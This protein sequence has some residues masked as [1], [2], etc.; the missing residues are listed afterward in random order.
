MIRTDGFTSLY[1][2]PSPHRIEKFAS[3]GFTLLAAE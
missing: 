3:Y 2:D 1:N